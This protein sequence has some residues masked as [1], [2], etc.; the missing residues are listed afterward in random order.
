MYLKT[1]C[2][3]RLFYFQRV[4]IRIKIL[5]N[6]VHFVTLLFFPG[7]PD[8]VVNIV[9]GSGE[10]AGAAMVKHPLVRLVS[11]TGSDRAGL[12]IASIAGAAAKKVSLEV[13]T[14]SPQKTIESENNGTFIT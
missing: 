2:I 9:F 8:G 5:Q 14:L 7:I 3:F 11:F 13:G 12:Q 1:Y 10:N 4:G 6:T